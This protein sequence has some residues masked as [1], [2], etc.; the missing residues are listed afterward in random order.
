[1]TIETAAAFRDMAAVLRLRSGQNIN[2]L[3]F[4]KGDWLLGRDKLQMNGT[5]WVA[6]VDWSLY[7]WTMWWDGRIR[8][9]RLGYVADGFVPPPRAE[10]GYLDKDQWDVW[11]KGSWAGRC[12]STIKR[13]SKKRCGRPTRWAAAMRWR[14]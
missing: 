14:R 12:R 11:N 2:K 6:R 5:Q 8:D 3:A 1:M 9:Y 4:V 13:R 7:G 10:L